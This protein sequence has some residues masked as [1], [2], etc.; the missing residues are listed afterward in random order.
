[1][2]KKTRSVFQ[3]LGHVLNENGVTHI[4]SSEILSVIVVRRRRDGKGLC[5]FS[6]ISKRRFDN[7]G[8]CKSKMELCCQYISV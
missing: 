6:T 1:M 7:N 8:I 5:R 4:V 2:K 3:G